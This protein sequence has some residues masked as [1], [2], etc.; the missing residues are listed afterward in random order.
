MPLIIFS[1]FSIISI[2]FTL[3]SSERNLICVTK[4]RTGL[5]SLLSFPYKQS[6][7]DHCFPR[8]TGINE[9]RYS[10]SLISTPIPRQ[11]VLTALFPVS[12]RNVQILS[13]LSSPNTSLSFAI[14]FGLFLALESRSTSFCTV[15]FVIL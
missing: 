2:R 8:S 1:I 3:Y 13:T 14:I 11:I 9:D 6:E 15:T 5:R 12:V 7:I 10:D 4:S